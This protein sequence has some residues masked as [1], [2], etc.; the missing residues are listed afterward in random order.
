MADDKRL[1]RVLVW[2]QGEVPD[3]GYLRQV[4]LVA[5]PAALGAPD[6]AG[7]DPSLVVP[8]QM[9]DGPTT[10]PD[11]FWAWALPSLRSP[12]DYS[13]PAR[14]D[15]SGWQGTDSRS[16]TRLFV[17]SIY[18]KPAPVQGEIVAPP[19]PA[20]PPSP[21]ASPPAPPDAAYSPLGSL[22][23]AHKRRMSGAPGCPTVGCQFAPPSPVT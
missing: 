14:Y 3:A 8:V 13:D 12:I 22:G 10:W 23:S 5:A 16:N 19:L 21:W 11:D 15:L 9:L 17:A 1:V 7:G 4:L 2:K 20:A 6:A 18:E